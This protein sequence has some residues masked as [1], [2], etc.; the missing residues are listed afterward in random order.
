MNALVHTAASGEKSNHIFLI[1]ALE[2]EC[3]T[4]RKVTYRL[5]TSECISLHSSKWRKEQPYILNCR[6]CVRMLSKEESNLLAE[7]K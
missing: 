3:Y 1:E 4:K 5:S 2:L 7:H 6:L